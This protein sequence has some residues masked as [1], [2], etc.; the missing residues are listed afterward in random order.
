MYVVWCCRINVL[1]D[2]VVWVGDRA[3]SELNAENRAN[4]CVC[5][6]CVRITQPYTLYTYIHVA[7]AANI[8]C[9]FF[10]V[11]WTYRTYIEKFY[12]LRSSTQILGILL[13]HVMLYVYSTYLLY[14][15]DCAILLCVCVCVVV[16]CCMMMIIFAMV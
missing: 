5:V 13:L 1:A 10:Q 12:V 6:C 8:T 15:F 16:R 3:I 9:F 2:T 11:L 4:G 7:C 14:T